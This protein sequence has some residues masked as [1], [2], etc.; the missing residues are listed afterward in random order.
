MY[1]PGGVTPEALKITD[2]MTP[3]PVVG[4]VEAEVDGDLILLS[5]Q[6]FSYFGA[7]GTGDAVWKLIDGERTVG[8]IIADLESN[9]DA[10][11][12]VIRSETL[13]FIEA[14]VVSGLI[15]PL[16]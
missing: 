8:A 11:E 2:D 6:D 7:A 1:Y 9:Y 16:K 12:G 4:S 3:T 10:P 5:P 15:E 14:L 13:E